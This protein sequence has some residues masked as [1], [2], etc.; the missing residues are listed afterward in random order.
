M[1]SNKINTSSYLKIRKIVIWWAIDLLSLNFEKCEDIFR[2]I[3]LFDNNFPVR[4]P[5]LVY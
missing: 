1:I 4:S 5:L 2:Q 3:F